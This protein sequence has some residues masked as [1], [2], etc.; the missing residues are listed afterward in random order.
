MAV[1]RHLK[2]GSGR[3]KCLVAL[4]C[5]FLILMFA[6]LEATHAH[7][8]AQLSRSAAGC[9]ICVS[10]HA[11]APAVSFNLLPTLLTLE[12]LAPAFQS[13]GKDFLRELSLLIR[14]PPSF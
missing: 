6:G 10:V 12:M 1:N 14:P 2:P 7:S 13:H 5:M 9:A 3:V 4:A 8:D 11:N